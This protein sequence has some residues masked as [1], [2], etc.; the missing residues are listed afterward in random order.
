MNSSSTTSVASLTE[1]DRKHLIHPASSF[2]GHEARGATILT[3]GKGMYLTDATGREVLDAFAGLWCV[4]AGY[5]QESIVRAAADQM[6]RLAYATEYFGFASE[7]AIRLAQRIVDLAPRSL[8]RVFFTLGG[9]DAVDSAVRYVVHYFNAQGNRNK[10][11][12]IAL[13]RSFHGSS[14]IGSGL[15]SL[16]SF[17]R[18]FDVP[19]SWQHR[20]PSPYPYRNPVGQNPEDIIRQSIGHLHTKVQ[21]LGSQNVAAFICE[22]IQGAGGVIVPPRGWLRAMRDTCSELGVLFIVDEVITG[23]GRTGKLFACEHEGIL[24][25]VMTVAKGLTSGYAPMGA[26]LISE[27]IY[28]TI[29]DAAPPGAPIGHGLTYSGH[30]VSSAV[31]LEV[32]RLYLEGG[33][34]ANA[35]A[36]A[37]P[38]SHGLQQL[39]D[40]PLV[41]DVRSLGLLGA[42]EL[43]CDKALRTQFDPGLQLSEKLFDIGYR[44]GIIFRAFADCTV[45]LAPALCCSSDNLQVMFH[46]LKITLDEFLGEPEVHR[47]FKP[48]R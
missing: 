3:S 13:E 1:L 30:P 31:A 41:G 42:V 33:L 29:A 19:H 5:G 17:H 36:M 44:N 24:P 43:V 15:T 7:P 40:H 18:N 20:I 32:L 39:Q 26:V 8:S 6:S 27:E 16:A 4:N 12:F 14:A 28:A 22:P 37:A 9:S 11:Q 2:R 35:Q 21:E 46:R 34:L 48:S 23:F 38:F 10:K 47:A 25:D 45:G